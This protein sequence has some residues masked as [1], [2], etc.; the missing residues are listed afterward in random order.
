MRRLI[1]LQ[2]ILTFVGCLSPGSAPS[3]GA[4]SPIVLA[5]GISV[6]GASS[7]E[8]ELLAGVS[9]EFAT[10]D[11][12][13]SPELRV[14]ISSRP[15]DCG[16]YEGT[17]A[18][19]KHKITLCRPPAREWD[20]LKRLARHELGHA[21]DD[22]NMTDAKRR[23]YTAKIGMSGEWLDDRLPHDDRPGERFAGTVAALAQGMIDRERFDALIGVR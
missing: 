18:Y 6:V 12:E 21:W 14:Q 16:E 13:M 23:H 4:A 11:L 9:L 20:A 3:T 10:A 19:R 5:G 22:H 7:S 2:L 15:A 8:L 17:Y 1:I